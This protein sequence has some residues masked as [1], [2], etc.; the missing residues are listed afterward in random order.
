M[1][2]GFRENSR[3]AAKYVFVVAMFAT[4]MNKQTKQVETDVTLV[5]TNC[6][7]TTMVLRFRHPVPNL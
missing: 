1:T 5:F 6:C 4:H 7:D 3:L 2:S